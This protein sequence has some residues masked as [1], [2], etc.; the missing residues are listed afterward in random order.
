MS[1]CSVSA[2]PKL[3]IDFLPDDRGEPATSR[4]QGGSSSGGA[5]TSSSSRTTSEKIAPRSSSG[6]DSSEALILLVDMTG[7]ALGRVQACAGECGGFTVEGEDVRAGCLLA[8]ST[9]S[10]YLAG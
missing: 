6:R 10:T 8:S 3:P 1:L 9:D 2:D 7:F 5:G 4:N